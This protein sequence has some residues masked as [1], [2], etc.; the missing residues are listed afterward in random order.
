M[1]TNNQAKTLRRKI[2]RLVAAARAHEWLGGSRP[3]DRAAIQQE[4][5]DADGDC[6]NYIDKLTEQRPKG[7][8]TKALGPDTF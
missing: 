3:E 2:R 6:V 1:I 7:W 4:L 5:E 8:R